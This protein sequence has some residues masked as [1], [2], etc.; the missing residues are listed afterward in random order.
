MRTLGPLC[1]VLPVLFV[2]ACAPSLDEATETGAAAATGS[3]VPLSVTSSGGTP[4]LTKDSIKGCWRPESLTLGCKGGASAPLPF[5]RFVGS[6]LRAR[7]ER[8]SEWVETLIMAKDPTSLP[9]E[10]QAAAIKADE[11]EVIA[12][13][14][15]LPSSCGKA[16][17]MKCEPHPG[18]CP[19]GTIAADMAPY[20][21]AAASWDG[22][23]AMHTVQA[24]IPVDQ[25]TF[26]QSGY[27]DA[28]AMSSIQVS[29]RGATRT[30]LFD[31][32]TQRGATPVNQAT[33]TDGEWSM[34]VEITSKT[35][36]TALLNWG[37]L[38]CK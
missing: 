22:P 7:Y 9:S 19:A 13:R 12:T 8:G 38:F 27:V 16:E 28:A 3:C 4:A 17:P 5:T 21:K 36:A 26:G 11:D 31:T 30:L 25:I 20:C 37:G 32:K 1:L 24:C 35:E 6:P 23:E 34:D 18:T 29:C 15:S 33:F 2:G 14:W 10:F